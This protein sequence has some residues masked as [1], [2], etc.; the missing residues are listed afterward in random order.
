MDLLNNI[1]WNFNETEY[2]SKEGFNE[3]I[4]Q[5]QIKI[6]K[7]ESSWNPNEIVIEN[8]V[9]DI[10]FM[11]WIEENGLAENETLLED[12][13]FFDDESN[14]EFGLFQA[15]IQVRLHA[16]NGKNFSALELMYQLDQ[17]MKPKELGDD[18]FFEGLG[19]LESDSRIPKFYLFCGSSDD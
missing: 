9:V 6:K 17:Q 16:E 10:V 13:D 14:S 18:L 19:G 1:A 8:P 4:S 7:Q 12:E 3:A 15:D 11:A 5:Y 2:D